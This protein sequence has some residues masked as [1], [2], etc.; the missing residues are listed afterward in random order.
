MTLVHVMSDYL[1][2]KLGSLGSLLYV[3]TVNHSSVVQV[4]FGILLIGNLRGWEGEQTEYIMCQIREAVKLS[5]HDDS[6]L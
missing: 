1:T 5:Q 2:D 6:M 4:G 3:R